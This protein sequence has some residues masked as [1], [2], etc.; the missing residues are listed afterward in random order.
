MAD[1][2]DRP[3]FPTPEEM[4]AATPPLDWR[5]AVEKT[6]QVESVLMRGDYWRFLWE[7]SVTCPLTYFDGE[8]VPDNVVH[9]DQIRLQRYRFTVA[10]DNRV[11]H[12]PVLLTESKHGF[13]TRHFARSVTLAPNR[14][15]RFHGYLAVQE[16]VQLR[17]AELRGLLIRVKDVGVGYY[18]AS[19][20]DWQVNQGPRSRWITG[21]IFVDEGLED[22]M[23]VDR[24]S[25]NRYHPEF[26]LLQQYVHR[27]LKKIMSVTY[28]K[29]QLRS[30]QSSGERMEFRQ[31]TVGSVITAATGQD[32][33]VTRG[34]LRHDP[35][36]PA[37]L[38]VRRK[39]GFSVRMAAAETLKTRKPRR[40]LAAAILALF[41]VCL[42]TTSDRRE[43]RTMFEKGL[44][45]L[46]KR[47][48]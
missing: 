1:R 28:R 45:D 34:Q 27:E 6:K 33:S 15:L 42:A 2:V 44:L 48:K 18:D 39:R 29:L 32:V 23:N 10:V 31:E 41:D 8:A 13:S 19:L 46:L 14:H 3:P 22:A 30:E 11:L 16:G 26:K 25:F 38:V 47:W 24:D 5:E 20:L 40:E 35:D 17:P 36:A 9:A 21:E 7:L 37:A 12:K 43:Q 4:Q